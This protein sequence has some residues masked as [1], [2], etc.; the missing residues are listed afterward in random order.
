MLNL[1]GFS[2]DYIMQLRA[3][4]RICSIPL[5]GDQAYCRS[6]VCQRHSSGRKTKKEIHCNARVFRGAAP[7]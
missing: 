2:L 3:V 7:L 1:V 5:S 6:H 4:P